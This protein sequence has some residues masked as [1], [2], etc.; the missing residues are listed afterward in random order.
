[1]HLSDGRTRRTQNIRTLRR[2]AEMGPIQVRAT[3]RAA[4]PV[5]GRKETLHLHSFSPGP[6]KR[7]YVSSRVISLP[8]CVVNNPANENRQERPQEPQEAEEGDLE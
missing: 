6:E 3:V 8:E 5:R 1:M 4:L 7:T 2:Q